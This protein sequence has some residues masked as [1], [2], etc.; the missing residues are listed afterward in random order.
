MHKPKSVIS[1]T[2]FIACSLFIIGCKDNNV[3]PPVTTSNIN[4]VAE[5]NTNAS[6]NG[7]FVMPIN[8]INYA[9][10]ADGTNGMQI[11]NVTQVNLPDS[12][13]S[14]DTDGSAND[15]T[16]ANISNDLYAF[17]S[18]YYS[19]LVIVDVSDPTN[20]VL[21]AVLNVAGG[22]AFVT[23][24]T[25]D[26]VN[27]IAYVG[28]STG[29]VS[30]FDLSPLPNE[31][32]FINAFT[33]AESVNGLYINNNLLYIAAGDDGFVIMDVTNPA[34]PELISANNTSGNASDVIVST[35]Y[36][37]VADSYNGMLIFNVTTPSSPVL[38]SR[39]APNGQ[40][41]GLTI[42]N[43]SLYTADNNYGVETVNVSNPS[44]P[45]QIGFF[46]S[47]G[48]ANNI[49]Y[50]GGYLFLAAAEE[51]LVILQPTN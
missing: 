13:S 15:I 45:S 12:V 30:V 31:P 24:T 10:I 36:A 14:F 9:F 23:T 43:N 49:F 34:V 21:A 35:N 3:D 38:L 11:I 37:Y 48:S 20:P 41:L 5:Y 1:L 2:I 50:F 4:L 6:T 7:I 19:G 47:Q 26:A 18:D 25:V 29:Q 17:I 51:G 42:N 40:I 33:R 28:L 32:N 44:S 39:F 27:E 8:F 46:D 16:V 22:G